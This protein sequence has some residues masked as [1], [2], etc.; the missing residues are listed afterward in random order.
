MSCV[1][2]DDGF[3]AFTY[4]GLG[5]NIEW[6]N[7]YLDSNPRPEDV[8]GIIMHEM[9][10]DYGFGHSDNSP[11]YQ[12]SVNERFQNCFN[13]VFPDHVDSTSARDALP[14]ET[15]LARAGMGGGGPFER[16]CP[17]GSW[18]AGLEVG[19]GNVLTGIRMRCVGLNGVTEG[20]IPVG[21]VDNAPSRTS[22]VCPPNAAGRTFAVGLGGGAGARIDRLDMTC[23][24]PTSASAPEVLVAVGGGGGGS[25]FTRRCPAGMAVAGI[26]GRVGSEIDGLSPV[27]RAMTNISLVTSTLPM[28]GETSGYEE[29]RVCSG[30]A[31]AVGLY[32]RS[33]A[34]IDRLGA[35][36]EPFDATGTRNAA[37][38]HI[39]PA[40]GG[41]GGT[42]FGNLDQPGALCAAG[43]ALVGVDFRSG[44][45][46]DLV[47]GVCASITAWRT[48]VV[49]QPPLH[50]LSAHGGGG[51][52][53]SI[54]TCPRGQFVVG[55]HTFGQDVVHAAQ[56]R[57]R[58]L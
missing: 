23:S 49:V 7:R 6:R 16:M 21:N 29:D 20:L 28:H 56:V 38:G 3:N 55:F 32:G 30:L 37:L 40:A 2:K 48:P 1:S 19:F 33:G 43:E 12:Y 15:E 47:R 57:C 35:Y 34:V 41:Y 18:V 31:P 4:G 17:A 36:C 26:R 45:R 11:E 24:T 8:A 13:A 25:P 22:R 51:G 10:H 39:T 14:N 42:G 27:C 9:A 54:D 52:S 58:A 46:V 53:V 5:E 44:T 50:R